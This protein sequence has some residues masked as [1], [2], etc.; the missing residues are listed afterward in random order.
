MR[1]SWLVCLLMGAAAWGQAAQGTP[2]AQSQVPAA[3]A[4]PQAPAQQAAADTAASVPADAAVITIHGVCEAPKIATAAAAKTPA[5]GKAAAKTPAADCKTVITK[6]QFEKMASALSPVPLNPQQK[7]QLA[8]NLGRFIPMVEA[9]KKRHLDKTPQFDETVKYAKMQILSGQLMTSIQKEAGDL[10]PADIDAYYKA[11]T[12]VFQQFSLQRLYVP[13]TK[14]PE[15]E[16][17]ED[18]KDQKDEKLSEEAQKAKQ[19]EEKAKA[20]E[21]EEAMTKLAHSLHDRAVA[22][23]DFVKLQKEA[24]DAAGMKIDSPTVALNKIRRTGLQ[25]SQASVFEL[26]PGDVSDVISDTGGHYIYK[27]VSK[28]EAPLEQVKDEIHSTLQ[29]QRYR[30]LMDKINGSVKVDQNDAYFGAG[31]PMIPPPR[32]PGA[33]MAPGAPAVPTAQ[34]QTPPPAQPPAAKPN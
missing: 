10:S 4:R 8:G 5:A 2:P 11:N 15:A 21:A 25:A 19:A 34:P 20:D 14:Q 18:E 13:R 27:M 32:M 6:A 16:K 3:I 29:N 23:E 22:G 26:K 33:R 28:D 1:K 9:A 17:E 7:K 24:F 31:G 30:E 12:P